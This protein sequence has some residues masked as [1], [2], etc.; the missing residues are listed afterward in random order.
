LFSDFASKTSPVQLIASRKGL[1]ARLAPSSIGASTSCA[2]RWI[3]CRP[4]LAD[5]PK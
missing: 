1:N 4:P 2:P 3:A 5:S